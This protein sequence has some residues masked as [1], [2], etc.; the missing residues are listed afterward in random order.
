MSI[1]VFE[2]P[3]L[4]GLFGDEAMAKLWS[5]QTQLTHLLTF[6]AAWTR[7]QGHCGLLDPETAETVAAEIISADIDMALLHA[8]TAKD[9]VPVPAMVTYLRSLTQCAEVHVGAT[10]QDVMDTAVTLTLK[11]SLHLL[12]GRLRHLISQLTGL[13]QTFGARPLMGRTRMQAALPTTLRERLLTWRLPLESHLERLDALK[14]RVCQLQVGGATGDRSALGAEQDAFIAALSAQLSMPVPT[15]AW[16]TMR[17]NMAE[18]ASTA[19]L[20]TG[21]L[22]KLGQDVALMA[23]Q[24]L[25]EI[26]LSSGGGSS[27]MPHKQNPIDAEALVSLARFNAVQLSGMHHAMVHEQE[28]S[29]AAWSL[30]WMILPNMMLAT[31]A[32]TRVTTKLL[33]NIL[34]MGTST[35]LN[36][37]PNTH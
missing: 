5:P 21:S 28:R 31:G 11:D 36:T 8:G 30:E 18:M 29:G 24:G 10:S 15:K 32:A 26:Q 9:G 16:H 25:D 34:D 12:E 2:H 13:E 1:S 35:E 3:W 23:Q 4:S 27:A 19:S 22:G 6:E 33:D 20:I 14:P 17:D 7:A 37:E